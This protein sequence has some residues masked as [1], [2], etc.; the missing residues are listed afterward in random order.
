MTTR[1]YI[2]QFGAD[3]D[4]SIRASVTEALPSIFTW[5]SSLVLSAYIVAHKDEVKGMRVLE[6][7]AGTGLVS[8]VAGL[9]GAKKVVATDRDLETTLTNL[10]SSI[11][12]NG[13]G[14]MAVCSARGFNWSQSDRFL[15]SNEDEESFDLILGADVLYSTEDFDD[16]LLAVARLLNS[17]GPGC[18]FITA[19]HDRSIHRSLAAHLEQYRLC[20]RHLPWP[21]H[22]V[23]EWG[24]AVT[25]TRSGHVKEAEMPS[26]DNIHLLEIT[27]STK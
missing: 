3:S 6:L 8:V 16:L 20:A 4:S 15:P 18:S 24:S 17:H 7:G 10:Q 27:R 26:F 19:Y 11:A 13:E 22:Q 25:I 5:P 23:H 21:L 12:S 9:V 1:S 14:L 2:F